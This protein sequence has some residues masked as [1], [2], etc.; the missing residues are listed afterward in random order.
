[1]NLF[2]LCYDFQVKISDVSWS[3]AG[4]AL[5]VG[6][7]ATHHEAWCDHLSE[8]KFY[9][10]SRDD[11]LIE[12][13]DKTVETQACVTALSYHPTEPSILAAGL[14]NGELCFM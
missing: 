8:I 4:G 10:L 1:M 11:R 7:S 13:A 6:Q 3:T 9:K 14:F 12:T 5:A 2:W